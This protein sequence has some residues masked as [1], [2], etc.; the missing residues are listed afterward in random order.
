MTNEWS[1]A[2]GP[3][4]M[5]YEHW[6]DVPYAGDASDPLQTL[7]LSC[8]RQATDFATVVWFHGGGLVSG[9][10]ECPPVLYNG[11][12]AVVEAR[13]R[14]SPAVKAPAYQEDAAAA[15][16]W[17]FKHITEYGGD[18]G[19]II[20]GGMSAGA[21]LAAIVGMDPTWLAP[22]GVYPTALAGLLL[23]SGQMTT[24][25][26]VKE[27]LAYPGHRYQPIVNELAP[28]SHLSPE[29]PPILLVT[30]DP[31]LDIP[32]RPAENAFM[33]ASL[34]AMGHPHIEC[35]HLSGHD[36]RGAFRSCDALVERFLGELLDLGQRPSD[37]PRPP[38]HGRRMGT[39]RP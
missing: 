9:G 6:R 21:Y 15:V 32:A 2:P 10:R 33:A 31:T 29:L 17:V 18:P 38:A 4:E 5:R 7:W 23:V 24:H 8:P 28:L 35:H 16:A 1:E 36:H 34:K 37:I 26:Q 30:G 13:Y 3:D 22:H 20:I 11:N 12:V 25:F 19:K 39:R 27:D 14:L